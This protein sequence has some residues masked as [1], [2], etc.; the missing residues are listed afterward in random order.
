MYREDFNILNSGII[1]FDNGATTLKPKILSEA[2]A[3]YYNNYSSNAHRG[4]YS[5]SIKASSMYEETRNLV[6]EMINANKASEIAFTSGTTD[7]INKIVF[8][9]FKY[10]LSKGDEV[11]LTKSEHASNLL[12]WF[13]LADELGLKIKYIE[14]DSN[15]EVKLENVE[16]AITNKTKVISIA[17]ISNVVGD[18]RPVEDIVKLA[19]SKGIL[20]LIDGAQSVPHI[21]VDVQKMDVD[22]LA[23]SAHKMCGPTGVGV[24]YGK[25]KLLN[26]IRPIIFGGGMNADFSHDGVRIYK[27]MPDRLEAGTP[28]V[29]GVIGF[30]YVIKYLMNIGFD[31]I[32][33]K[34]LEL[35]KYLVKRLKEIK[36]ITI[37]NEY[38]ESG[39]VTINYEGIFPQDLSI[40]LDKYNICTRAGNHCAKILKDEIHIKNTCRIS[41]YFYNCEEEIDKLILAL[42]NPKIKEDIIF[43]ASF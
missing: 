34:E 21:K 28:N 2:V 37:Y 41:L 12:P 32:Q 22:F 30:G 26:E 20:V 13:E 43:Q 39:I 6:K 35:K 9:F 1:Y 31:N 14:L 40:Y 38:S 11:L 17:H 19:H 36:E 29:A 10:H 27:T 23:F 15:H 5:L 24:I 16:K 8:G 3:D 18:V 42:K 4:D 25:E 33:K 7:S